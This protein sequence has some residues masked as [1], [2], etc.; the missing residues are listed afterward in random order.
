MNLFKKAKPKNGYLDIPPEQITPNPNQPRKS[1][2]P[3]EM[4]KLCESIKNSGIIQPLCVRKVEKSY[5][6]ISGERRLRAAKILELKTVPCVV[7]HT[8]NE[9]SCIIALIENIQRC[10]LS[11]F[12]EAAGIHKLIS[13]YG[14]TQHEAAQKLGMSQ[15]SIANKLR[16]LRLSEHQRER[17]DNMQLTERHARALLRLGGEHQRDE[18]LNEIIAK[19]YNVEETERYIDKLLNP[20]EETEKHKPIRVKDIRL[21]VNTINNAVNVM[22]VSGINAK[23]EK[24]ETENHIIYTVTIPKPPCV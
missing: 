12:D 18:V 1:F 3:E 20:P 4:R 7:T 14:L 24:E 9:N 5:E 21:F 19:G 23:T 6:L 15:S 16:L 17:I 11:F 22:K 13:E 10:D 2:D 8:D